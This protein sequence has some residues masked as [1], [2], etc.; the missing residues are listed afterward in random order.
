MLYAPALGVGPFG[1]TPA[2]TEPNPLPGSAPPVAE[3]EPKPKRGRGP[4][5]QKFQ[6]KLT[7]EQLARRRQWGATWGQVGADWKRNHTN[8]QEQ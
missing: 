2:A 4:A 7:E 3:G 1:D 6:R 8:R 5:T